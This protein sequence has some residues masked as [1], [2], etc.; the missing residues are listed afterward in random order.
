MIRFEKKSEPDLPSEAA[1]KTK[2]AENT[3]DYASLAKPVSKKRG[4]KDATKDDAEETL[5]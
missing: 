4:R 2:P 1:K 5:L 3:V